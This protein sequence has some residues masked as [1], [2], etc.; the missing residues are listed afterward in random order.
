MTLGTLIPDPGLPIYPA[1]FLVTG[2]CL[3]VDVSV[4]RSEVNPD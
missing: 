4:L 3:Y 2:S 1:G